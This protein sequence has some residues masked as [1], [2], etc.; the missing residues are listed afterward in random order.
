MR[1]ILSR[2]GNTMLV[3]TIILSVEVGILTGF[4]IVELAHRVI[5]RRNLAKYEAMVTEAVRDGLAEAFAPSEADYTAYI[6]G[7][8][9]ER[10]T[11]EELAELEEEQIDNY[12]DQM[13]DNQ[14][15]NLL[16]EKY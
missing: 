1:E 7:D 5:A 13:I 4:G 14:I 11:D 3:I 15:E 12:L 2:K 9:G 16:L 8:S 10:Y 6:N